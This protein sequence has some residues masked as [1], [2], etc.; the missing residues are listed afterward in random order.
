MIAL[1]AQGILP[2]GADDFVRGLTDWIVS[3]PVIFLGLAALPLLLLSSSFK[4][5]P[6]TSLLR[7]VL[8]LAAAS[9]V[10]IGESTARAL[11]GISTALAV[12]YLVADW[13]PRVGSWEKRFVFRFLMFSLIL[14]PL[15]ITATS[16]VTLLLWDV[17]LVLFGA[18]DLLTLPRLGKLE[19]VRKTLRIASLRK[20]HEVELTVVNHSS[21]TMRILLIDD[22]PQGWEAT[23]HDF[24]LRLRPRTRMI[25]PY[26]VVPEPT[27]W[28]SA[29]LCLRAGP[30]WDGTLESRR[31][32]PVRFRDQ[33]LSRHG[34]T[35]GIRAPGSHESTAADGGA[36]HA[37]HWSG[38]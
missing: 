18:A 38:Q 29:R 27:R 10:A 17:G 20:R 21:W 31:E 1:L 22:R 37:A 24:D 8:V 6:S 13:F 25:F 19:I 23:P 15:L 34:S 9:I 32:D 2:I 5:H 11:G 14:P 12:G 33:G 7:W 16:P 28:F 30:E 3:A 35:T 4:I 26:R 36:T